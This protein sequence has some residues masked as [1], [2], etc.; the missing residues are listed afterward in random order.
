MEEGNVQYVDSPVTVSLPLML[1]GARAEWQICGDIH[2]QFF[3]L[4]ELFNIGGMCPE[5]NYI[6][7]GEWC[8]WFVILN[9]EET[10]DR[11]V[12]ARVGEKMEWKQV[13][14]GGQRIRY[15]EKWR[16]RRNVGE[17]VENSRERRIGTEHRRLFIRNGAVRDRVERL[18]SRIHQ[19]GVVA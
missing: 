11:G 12:S 17:E 14:S 7:M 4:M 19:N 15:R 1:S 16:D 2:G 9:T 3:D 8:F 5:T 10:G 18:S 13:D 6:F